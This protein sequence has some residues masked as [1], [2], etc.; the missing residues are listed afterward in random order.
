MPN[1][2]PENTD[3]DVIVLGAGPAGEN[4]ADYCVRAGLSAAIVESELVGGE[5]SYWACMPSKALLRSGQVLDAARR[6][7][8]AQQAATG[9]I[10]AAAVF[11]RRDYFTS[12]WKDA[13]QVEWLRSAGI[14][15]L[16]GYGRLAGPGKVSIAGAVHT[17]R[18]IVVATGS[19]PVL[20]PI[21]GLAEAQPWDTRDATSAQQ[22]PPR[23]IIIGG[24]VAG[25]EMAAA[26]A[27]LPS[28]VTILAR[29]KLL[30]AEEPFAGQ[31]VAESLRSHGVQVHLDTTPVR[32]DRDKQ[33]IVQAALADGQ[34]LHAEQILV[35]TGRRANT[36]DLGLEALGMDPEL[37]RQVDDTL[38]VPGTDWLYAV[39]DAN[40]RSLLTHQG[41]YQAR[42]AAA[43]I[44]A[45][46]NGGAA[47]TASW[48]AAVASA[49]HVAVPRVVFSDPQV[50]AVGLTSTQAKDHGFDVVVVE[51]DLGAVAGASLHADCYA[52]R[53]CLVV[54][55]SRSVLL[56]ATFVGQ[57]AA[58]LLHAATIAIVGQVPL[59]RLWHAV[60]AYPTISEIWLRLLE[61]YFYPPKM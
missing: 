9:A 29:G 50:A 46:L 23:L 4:V 61:D 49:D 22:A 21:P 53:A 19:R 47:D 20:P 44:A 38:L 1:P 5:C 16:R 36:A 7:P 12:G 41:K 43:A 33:G 55:T 26:Y 52:G 11:T 24:G 2:D 48:S 25:V 40:S 35:A 18:A 56:G 13:G 58:E 28:T 10:D 15:L 59:Q 17:A 34:V 45:R 30:S 6:V 31:L 8:G 14:T 32:V 51:H 60:P 39:G 37:L 57:D 3:F 27:S 54:D 42:A